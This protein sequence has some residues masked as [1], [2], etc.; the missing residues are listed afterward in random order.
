MR[1]RWFA[2]SSAIGALLF[3]AL[4][5]EAAAQSAQTEGIA[6][7]VSDIVINQNNVTVQFKVTNNRKARV[8]LTDARTDDSQNAF[9]GSSVHLSFPAVAN[10]T[11]CNSSAAQ[12]IAPYC[13]WGP[14]P[15][16]R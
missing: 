6:F 13:R 3:S 5:N 10:F 7:A 12:C 9:L 4:L 1:L 2:I 11:F 16:P 15:Q 8:Y 14:A